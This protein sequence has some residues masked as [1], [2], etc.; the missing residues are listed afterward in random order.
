MYKVC[1]QNNIRGV[2]DF[3]NEHKIKP[4]YIIK[5]FKDNEIWRIIYYE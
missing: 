5:V 4:E 1:N 3:L 2:L